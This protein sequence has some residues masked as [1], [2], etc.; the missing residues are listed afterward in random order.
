MES[1]IIP[2]L[3]NNV[4]LL[5]GP[6]L[7]LEENV[8][9]EKIT[10]EE[11]SAFFRGAPDEIRASIDIKNTKCIKIHIDN[12]DSKVTKQYR[13]KT[14]FCLNIFRHK[15]PALYS[16]AGILHGE[17]KL[18][19]KDII[20]F[21]ALSG[22]NKLRKNKFKIEL[23]IRRKTIIEF[24]KIINQ[25]ISANDRVFFAL[26]KFNSSLVRDDFYDTLIDTT[27]CFETLT[28]G[29]TE[30]VYR[31]SQNISFIVGNSPSEREQAFDN[32]KKL[33]DVRSK[34]VHGDVSG[35]TIDKI[36]EVR[37]N[38]EIYDKYLKSAIIY[39]LIFLSQNSKKEWENHLKGII[40]GTQTKVVQ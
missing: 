8:F 21:E 17:R 35:K 29:S 26:D 7:Y 13:T 33:Y 1:I 34:I 4:T 28:P 11:H 2:L 25:A 10:D 5:P 39:Y 38:W 23:S 32:M 31:L 20:E 24:Y 15:N 3:N 40:L 18:R 12:A 9:L 22:F 19:I 6:P 16:W 27:I 14:I 30:L 36:E 37:N